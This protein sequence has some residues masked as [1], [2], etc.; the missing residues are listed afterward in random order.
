MPKPP[1]PFTTDGCSGGMSWIWRKLFGKPPPWDG[2]CVEHDKAY[3]QG[4]DAADRRAA[5]LKLAADV[6][7]RGYPITGALMY[8]GVRLGGVPW[9]PTSWRWGYGYGR[10]F[11]S[12]K[13]GC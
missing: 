5:D 7:L 6:S 4:G 10:K 3:W 2:D 11:G 13:E 12:Y 9:L 8:Y 1:I